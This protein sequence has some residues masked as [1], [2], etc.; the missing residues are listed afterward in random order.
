MST[1]RVKLR[2]A[3]QGLLDSAVSG[4]YSI[5]RTIYVMGPNKQNRL[6]KDGDTF[7]DS[8]YWKRFAYPQTTYENAFIEV[9]TDDGS[10]YSDDP[11]ENTAP[12]VYNKAIAAGS[13]YSAN[14]CDIMG[15]T[16]GWAVFCQIS[17]TGGG[18]VRV[19]VNGLTG[20]IF[21]LYDG[22]EQIF[23]AGDLSISKL[24]FDSSGSGGTGTNIQVLLS[25]KSVSRS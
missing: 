4:N 19:R 15:D 1:F 5:Q 22:H 9:V 17:N 10:I 13:T 24:E 8:N 25:V 18:D 14:V 2:N 7:T 20:A 12:L 21:D 23:N 6:L 3:S 16:G 11:S